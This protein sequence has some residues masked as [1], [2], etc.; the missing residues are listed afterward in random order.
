M[1]IPEKNTYNS[2]GQLVRY[3]SYHRDKDSMIVS[4]W[5]NK[6]IVLNLKTGISKKAKEKAI[7]QYSV[8]KENGEVKCNCPSAEKNEVCKHQIAVWVKAQNEKE[9][10][11]AEARQYEE[12]RKTRVMEAVS[13]W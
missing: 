3:E 2:K 12:E 8:T 11:Q 5:G 4:K 9:I 1:I 7:R 10:R 6:Y 13:R